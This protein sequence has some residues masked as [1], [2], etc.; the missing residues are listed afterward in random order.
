VVRLLDEAVVRALMRYDKP[1]SCVGITVCSE[2]EVGGDC[3]VEDV[4]LLPMVEVESVCGL[5]NG[6]TSSST[7]DA[8]K[9]SSAE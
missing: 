3:A 1:D 9:L 7:S 4:C 2:A 5:G 6:G 8:L